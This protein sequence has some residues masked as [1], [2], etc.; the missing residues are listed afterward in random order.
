MNKFIKICIIICLILLLLIA[1]RYTRETASPADPEQ[2]AAKNAT[3]MDLELAEI[4][5]QQDAINIAVKGINLTQGESG[6][7]SWR[8]SAKS[9]TLDQESGKINIISPDIIYF[10]KSQESKLLIT[11]R[12]GK[13][14]Q[15][16]SYVELWDDVQIEESDNKLTSSKAVYN[17]K[18]HTV[19]LPSPLQ[20]LNPQ[21][22][23]SAD[24]AEWDLKSNVITASGNVQVTI[25]S[26]RKEKQK[27]KR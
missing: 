13:L 22:S 19:I 3:L 8:L 9:A 6:E 17:G 21:F 25:L 24:Q 7:E 4:T 11:S 5:E 2:E 20:L 12:L 15:A 23:G 1:F 26:P 14:D 10:L 18:M 27:D 16:E